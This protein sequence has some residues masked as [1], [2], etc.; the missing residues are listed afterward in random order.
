MELELAEI[1][2]GEIDRI[3]PL[4]EQLNAMHLASS[5]HFQERCRTLTFAVRMAPVLEKARQGR[6][7]IDVLRDVVADRLVGYCLSTAEGASGAVDS[8][9]IEEAYRGGGQGDRLLGRALEW[10]AAI[11][12]G[13]I[14]IAVVHGHDAVLPFYARHGFYPAMHLLR[15]KP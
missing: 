9:F 4:W 11:G 10:L 8:I 1:P 14:S 2:V 3:Q 6:V 7:R 12:A 5:T 13:D 15:R